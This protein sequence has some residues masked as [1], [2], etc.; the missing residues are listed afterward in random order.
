MS[1]QPM[2]L[3]SIDADKAVKRYALTLRIKVRTENAKVM[4]CRQIEK[5]RDDGSALWSVCCA[6]VRRVYGGGMRYVF[7]VDRA[8]ALS[9]RRPIFI[10]MQYIKPIYKPLH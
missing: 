2:T 3:V 10:S 1:F 8:G 5:K 7:H 9:Y 6:V 4:P